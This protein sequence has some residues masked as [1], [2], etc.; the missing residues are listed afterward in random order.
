VLVCRIT[1]LLLL[2]SALAAG[3]ATSEREEFLFVL[4]PPPGP[5]FQ[6][7]I[8]VLW[9]PATVQPHCLGKTHDQCSA[10]DY[11]IRTT[12]RNVSQCRNLA[13]DVS[14]I[15]KYPAGSYPAR[16]LSVTY[17]RAADTI[18]NFSK[19][20]QYVDASPKS[21]FDRLSLKSRIKARIR[22]KRSADD[23]DFELLE[24]LAVPPL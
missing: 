5:T 20:L 21:E 11:C 14:R 12:N 13:V 23:D 22:V 19:L 6:G 4:N 18:K 15:P 3:P 2:A 10:I 9:I 7:A 24:V 8:Q 1:G 17:F 16:V